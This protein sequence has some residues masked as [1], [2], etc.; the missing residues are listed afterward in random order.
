[1]TAPGRHKDLDQADRM[2]LIQTAF[3]VLVFF[4]CALHKSD[5]DVTEALQFLNYHVF[6]SQVAH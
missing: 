4:S 3:S 2:I 5:D 1:M 6:V